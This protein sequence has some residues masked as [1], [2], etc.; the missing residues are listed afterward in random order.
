MRLSAGEGPG[1]RDPPNARRAALEA[2]FA[3]RGHAAFPLTDRFDADALL[4][5]LARR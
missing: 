5:F 3:G 1:G 4:D 2:L